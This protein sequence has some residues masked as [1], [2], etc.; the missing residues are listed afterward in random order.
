MTS[1][2]NYMFPQKEE[3]IVK[4]IFTTGSPVMP[5][6]FWD[7][8][9][10]PYDFLVISSS[11]YPL[12]VLMYLLC[13]A[14]A[15]EIL[16]IRNLIGVRSRKYQFIVESLFTLF[17]GFI[18]MKINFQPF[19]DTGNPEMDFI[20][21]AV[22]KTFISQSIIT[23]AMF[24]ETYSSDE[25][26]YIFYTALWLGLSCL[27]EV[28]SG[29][30]PYGLIT[31]SLYVAFQYFIEFS[32]GYRLFWKWQSKK[33]ERIIFL[34]FSYVFC[35]NTL[36]FYC[37]VD[38]CLTQRSK[39]VA[40]VAFLSIFPWM[41]LMNYMFFHMFA[42]S[43][44][45]YD[46]ILKSLKTFYYSK[47][48]D[49]ISL[50]AWVVFLFIFD[51]FSFTFIGNRFY[52]PATIRNR[53]WTKKSN[54]LSVK[55]FNYDESFNNKKLLQYRKTYNYVFL[56]QLKGRTIVTFSADRRPCVFY[57]PVKCEKEFLR[58]I[59]NHLSTGEW[60]D[61]QI[62][63]ESNFEKLI[64]FIDPGAWRG[65]HLSDNEILSFL[66][67]RFLNVPFQFY[68]LVKDCIFE[69]VFRSVFPYVL[70]PIE[71]YIR[72][73][74]N[75][76][77]FNK[78]FPALIFHLLMEF[79]GIG[80]GYRVLLHVLFNIPPYISSQWF[81][82][83]VME[84]LVKH[85][86]WL[87]EAS[88][89]IYLC[90]RFIAGE[91]KDWLINLF[92]Y[93]YLS[94][95]NVSLVYEFFNEYL[96]HDIASFR[97][98]FTTLSGKEVKETFVACGLLDK[99]FKSLPAFIVK[100]PQF[101]TIIKLCTVVFS[102]VLSSAFVASYFP[103]ILEGCSWMSNYKDGFEL[104][105][106]FQRN[107]VGG[108]KRV[109]DGGG[110]YSF[111]SDPREYKLQT[112]VIEIC[113]SDYNEENFSRSQELRLTLVGNPNYSRMNERLMSWE[114][115]CMAFMICNDTISKIESILVLESVPWDSIL[116]HI[117]EI[118]ILI[119]TVLGM[120]SEYHKY[121]PKLKE[122]LDQVQ[123]HY[124]NN[125]SRTPP[126]VLVL[127][128]KPGGG[129]T[130]MISS[131][132]KM[133]NPN[134]NPDEIGTIL[135]S[136]KYPGEG[137][138][139]SA[140]VLIFNDISG[141]FKDDVANGKQSQADIFKTL[142]DST[143]FNLRSASI[144][145][146]SHVFHCVELVIVTANPTSWIFAENTIALYRRFLDYSLCVEISFVDG[147]GLKDPAIIGTALSGEEFND[148]G[149]LQILKPKWC[150]GSPN[151]LSFIYVKQNLIR[152]HRFIPHLM[153]KML[154]HRESV[155]FRKTQSSSLCPC[156]SNQNYHRNE[157][158]DFVVFKEGVCVP[159][160]IAF[161]ERIITCDQCF[162]EKDFAHS[163]IV[164][165]NTNFV[166]ITSLIT[167]PLIYFFRNLFYLIMLT[168]YREKVYPIII[169]TETR[170]LKLCESAGYHVGN[171]F[172]RS[173]NVH[174]EK[175]VVKLMETTYYRYICMI[176]DNYK[177]IMGAIVTTSLL[178]VAYD[179]YKSAFNG[180]KATMKVVR[181]ENV[182]DFDLVKP[183]K[184]FGLVDPVLREKFNNHT[185]LVRGALKNV[186]V[187]EKDLKNL[188]SKR[189]YRFMY[190]FKKEGSIIDSYGYMVHIFAGA[191]LTALHYFEGENGAYG[192]NMILKNGEQELCLPISKNDVVQIG[193]V[194]ACLVKF[195]PM[196]NFKD[197]HDFFS[198]ELGSNKSFPVEIYDG[199]V[200]RSTHAGRSVQKRTFVNA[201]DC[202]EAPSEDFGYGSCGNLCVSSFGNQSFVLGMISYCG[203]DRTGKFISVGGPII[204]RD[205]IVKANSSFKVF[206]PTSLVLHCDLSQIEELSPNSKTRMVDSNYLIPVG[207]LPGSC[208]SF[209][210]SITKSAMEP[211]FRDDLSEPYS[212]PIKIE[213]K[214]G[215]EWTHCYKVSFK[216]INRNCSLSTDEFLP[217]VESYV[218]HVCNGVSI[219]N[220][221]LKLRPLT[222]KECFFGYPEYDVP[223]CN[224]KSSTGPCGSFSKEKFSTRKE[225]FDSFS[226]CDMDITDE[227]IDEMYVCNEEFISILQ[228]FHDDIFSG[229]VPVAVTM[230]AEKDEVRTI[231]KLNSMK[232]RIF[233][234]FCIYL[235]TL[236]K[237]Y[238]IPL[239]NI[240]LENPFFSKCF[241]K[242]NS[243]STEWQ[244]FYNYLGKDFLKFEG[245][246][247]SYDNSH[248]L[249]QVEM[250]GHT[251][252][253]FAIKWYGDVEIAKA[254]Y[255]LTYT[256]ALQIFIY[257]N[258]VVLKWK[259]LLSGRMDTL[260]F[261]SIDNVELMI[262]AFWKFYPGKDFF[263]YVKPG[264]L[265][266]DNLTG[267]H[268]DFSDFS[269]RNLKDVFLDWGYVLTSA[270]K[271]EVGDIDFV[272][273]DVMTFAKRTFRFDSDIGSIVAP[274]N[275]DSIY[276]MLCFKKDRDN[277]MT[278]VQ[279]YA[280][281][282]DVAARE[283]FLH[284]REKY[285]SFVSRG[286][287]IASEMNIPAEWRTFD[288][289]VSK[290]NSREENFMHW[291]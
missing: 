57:Y 85:E 13:F 132:I 14:F 252:Y 232:I 283:F 169:A 78:S 134:I 257:R 29:I 255:I 76:L 99:I 120:K 193:N 12:L 61:Y 72:M 211:F 155:E 115:R 129:K 286:E 55:V 91:T 267:I 244:D 7:E 137:V 123:K 172:L 23:Y 151:H 228:M 74:N 18:D 139:R 141:D 100:S 261:N 79:S 19:S 138:N 279:H 40:I 201:F 245:D 156:G 249:R 223:S 241:G 101:G 186:N 107:I 170:A 145:E 8:S 32:V 239:F 196:A 130:S 235:N 96:E 270:Q 154:F 290:Y 178:K 243:G 127:F 1:C 82:A 39:Y 3:E 125:V 254:C 260:V 237:M 281:L 291:I 43:F 184:S 38:L 144:G 162:L 73:C 221:L 240:L 226:V 142:M 265:G 192:G 199:E 280:V 10:L 109:Y 52:L 75:P 219:K 200:F 71:F 185:T 89:I 203:A 22:G 116:L 238:L 64:N 68:Y 86:H 253:L 159:P 80:F 175:C 26:G 263:M 25:S 46:T 189:T 49:E 66:E 15:Q 198:E 11:S 133:W 213:G 247:S 256:L 227:E 163:C 69:E 47:H 94:I 119:K 56:Q 210:S 168:N 31:I 217:A 183:Y 171:G 180:Y 273:N 98:L 190:S 287:K 271:N 37:V 51:L 258:D 165:Q 108:L 50:G 104:I 54:K 34:I 160:V 117:D 67:E 48:L 121:L 275:Q 126:F 16:I 93:G 246:F 288:Y 59:R 212:Y 106:D 58:F 229:R 218:D 152:Y 166:V 284:G 35:P 208:G 77:D 97:D 233:Y 131:A 277:G 124:R 153:E 20:F 214:V 27:F 195:H 173:L 176:F 191:Y 230:G 113:A 161:K 194:D 278:D 103:Y 44:M 53:E 268:P 110:L 272:S 158:G 128:G 90:E 122:R 28:L 24:L 248:G 177:S 204:T 147:Q 174:K 148:R 9:L 62:I 259:G 17:V 63:N 65:A 36:Y 242:M 140:K 289:F 87:R 222:L 83:T 42:I 111:F 181:K 70:G 182:A 41:F 164:Y 231:S 276:R 88:R 105:I 114:E 21:R 136:D 6:L 225:L 205:Q 157:N 4:S 33:P 285:D 167:I 92:N 95:K 143:P 274:L 250:V 220:P 45:S 209:K 269:I 188:I 135:S 197:F 2:L 262:I 187:A 202:W 149:R 102:S 118:K 236:M 215:D 216:N 146:K 282:L 60:S 206:S 224:W 81:K 150:D 84:D 30:I 234:T 251:V 207:T 266:D 5:Q 179:Y 112:K 264:T